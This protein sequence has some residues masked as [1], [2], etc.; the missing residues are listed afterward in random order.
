MLPDS[1]GQEAKLDGDISRTGLYIG[2]G[3]TTMAP[4]ILSLILRTGL[5]GC[6]RRSLY[7]RN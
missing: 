7:S 4:G 5:E 3:I 1:K 6:R 2:S